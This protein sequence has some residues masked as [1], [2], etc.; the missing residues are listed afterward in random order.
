M[1]G[2]DEFEPEV[3]SWVMELQTCGSTSC[4]VLYNVT[5]QQRLPTL[6]LPFITPTSLCAPSIGTQ[7]RVLFSVTIAS[8]LFKP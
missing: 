7:S 6:M 4:M 8:L 5:M 3:S 2:N 1:L